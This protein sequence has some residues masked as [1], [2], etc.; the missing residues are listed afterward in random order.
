MFRELIQRRDPSE[1]RVVN[2][3]FSHINRYLPQFGLSGG[4]FHSSYYRVPYK[5]TRSRVKTV[6]TVHDFLYEKYVSGLAKSVHSFQKRMA[7]MHSDAVI[8]VSESTRQDLL[9]FYGHGLDYKTFVV[10]NGVSD[11]YSPSGSFRRSDFILFVGPR[12]G[13]KNFEALVVAM[14]RFPDLRLTFAGGGALTSRELVLL[15]SHL[16]GRFDALGGVS[17][18]ML[19]DLY[20]SC[21]FFAYPSLYEG[22]GIPPLEA[23]RCGAAVLAVRSSCT[24]E[25][26]GDSVVLVDCGDAN[27]LAEG[28]AYLCNDSIAATFAVMGRK[29]AAFYSWDRC[30]EETDKIYRYLS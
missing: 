3:G 25:I 23:M 18:G 14:G 4:I 13:Y 12:G 17:Q 21:R 24:E 19:R 29:R 5:A 15:N 7:V 30:Y 10:A 2:V 8:C 28:I 9:E 27:S 11:F 26:L 1:I 16:P 22:F 20:R 6:T